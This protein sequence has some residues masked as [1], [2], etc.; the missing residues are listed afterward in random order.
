MFWNHLIGLILLLGASGE[1]LY[2]STPGDSTHLTGFYGGSLNS[3]SGIL[4]EFDD[5][6]ENNY[7]CAYHGD[8]SQE[9]LFTQSIS[10]DPISRQILLSA[11]TDYQLTLV[12]TRICLSEPHPTCTKDTTQVQFYKAELDAEKIG[13]FAFYNSDVYFILNR[14]TTL[15]VTL[16]RSDTELRKLTGCED[17]Y[18]IDSSS[19]FDLD[20]CSS[21][22]TSLNVE[23]FG[24]RD[25]RQITA[26]DTL[27]AVPEGSDQQ[28]SFF[29]LLRNI[30]MDDN[31]SYQSLQLI[32]V[33]VDSQGRKSTLSTQD[34]STD[35]LK[36]NLQQIGGISYKDGEICWSVIDRILCAEWNSRKG[37]TNVRVVLE[38]GQGK[39]VC[40]TGECII[41]CNELCSDVI[42]SI[43][44]F[45]P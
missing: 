8:Q 27:L 30:T 24:E 42:M 2:F 16:T 12:S 22:I 29:V 1:D 33:L 20:A 4:G 3:T 38:R 26:L 13:P 37:L 36:Y 41:V 17:S 35:F 15:D 5:L 31:G 40:R 28:P 45:S 25:S 9:N 34:V 11:V 18:P 19:A 14:L 23:Q 39:D 21:L 10:L 6:F 44:V 7:G 43:L 32:L